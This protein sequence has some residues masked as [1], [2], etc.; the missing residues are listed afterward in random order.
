[1]KKAKE[2]I[3]PVLIIIIAAFG[4]INTDPVEEINNTVHDS[5]IKYFVNN[6]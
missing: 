3:L 5:A 6:N 1:M 4:G 2:I